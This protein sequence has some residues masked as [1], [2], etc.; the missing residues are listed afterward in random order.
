MISHL[1]CPKPEYPKNSKQ[2]VNRQPR[3]PPGGL[4]ERP[5]IFKARIL[6]EKGNVFSSQREFAIYPHDRF[7]KI[8]ED[9]HVHGEMHMS[10]DHVD[11]VMRSSRTV[12]NDTTSKRCREY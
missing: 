10:L 11:H 5:L 3:S 9:P 8:P 2:A 1:P 7:A 6:Y 4:V 12:Q